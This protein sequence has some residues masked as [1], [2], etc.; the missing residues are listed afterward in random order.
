MVELTVSERR[1]ISV[2]AF[3][4]F[5]MRRNQSAEHYYRALAKFCSPGSREYRQAMAGLAAVAIDTGS[6]DK[7]QAAI[8]EAMSAGALSSQ[9]SALLL[10]KAQSLWLQGR[11]EEADAAL[12]EYRFLSGTRKEH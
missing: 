8:R 5:R 1:A 10:M 9:D 12:Q 7:A 2:L 11:T 4:M 6:A 3:M